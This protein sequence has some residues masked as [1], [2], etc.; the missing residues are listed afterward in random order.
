MPLILWLLGTANAA[1]VVWLAPPAPE[2]EAAVLSQAGAAGPG[3]QLAELAGRAVAWSD[4]DQAA[5]VTLQAAL[6]DARAFEQRLDGELLI[7]RDLEAPL[8]AI[9]VVRDETDRKALFAA[10]A[11][12]GFA[13]ERFFED[14]LHDDERGAP[15]RAEVDGAILP[16][17][18][19]DAVA[20]EPDKAVTAY[21]IAEA[22]Q[23]VAYERAREHVKAALPA[24]LAI[25]ELPADTVLI[26]DGREVVPDAQR[27]VRATPGRH[28]AHLLRG[29]R[30]VARWSGRVDAAARVELPLAV[31]DGSEWVAALPAT[32]PKSVLRDLR[33]LD[34]EVWIVDPSGSR[35]AGWRFRGGQFEALT[36]EQPRKDSDVSP[37]A[38]LALGPGW[39]STADYYRQD[40]VNTDPEFATVNAP[41]L[42]IHTSAGVDAGHLRVEA[43]VDVWW[44]PGD[45]HVAIWRSQSSH[46]R[47][48]PHVAI[49]IAEAR[50]AIGWLT[51][52]HLGLGPRLALPL[53]PVEIVGNGTIGVAVV[54]APDDG[55]WSGAP[56]Y[57]AWLGIGMRFGE[58]ED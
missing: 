32:P 7:M 23:R 21:E 46:V 39:M 37:T 34:D 13:I 57:S 20:L 47:A 18:W 15:F 38:S 52:H 42:V 3:T 48:F 12:Q 26:L 55:T 30:I 24:T 9:G 29:D 6:G 28:F 56:V 43:G 14:T 40:P 31:A 16:R 36:L 45:P 5:L 10:L 4:A 22:P 17:P 2:I 53:G 19:V 33:S 58:T 50:A 11:Y 41:G 27:L 54:G 51:P 44:T 35:P 49:G 1:E 25:P 8:E